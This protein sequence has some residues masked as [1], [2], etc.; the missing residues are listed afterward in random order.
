[1]DLSTK[2]DVFE[3]WLFKYQQKLNC[4]TTKLLELCAQNS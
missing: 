3:T 4:L 1:M 2:K